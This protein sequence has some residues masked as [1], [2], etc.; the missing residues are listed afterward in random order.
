MYLLNF[1]GEKPK[2]WRV[3]QSDKKKIFLHKPPEALMLFPGFLGFEGHCENRRWHCDNKH[4]CGKKNYSMFCVL[5]RPNKSLISEGV[6]QNRSHVMA[7]NLRVPRVE[8][9]EMGWLKAQTTG[10]DGHRALL[11]RIWHQGRSDSAPW[12]CF[13]LKS[14]S[15]WTKR[16]RHASGE[17][18][19]AAA[20]MLNPPLSA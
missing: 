14:S 3:N 6:P 18:A 9:S 1:D 5:R 20:R 12:S 16:S 10:W 11:P 4:Y 13:Q 17:G 2:R 15:K 19:N 7:T 8:A